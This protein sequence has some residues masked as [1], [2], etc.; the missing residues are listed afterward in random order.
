MTEKEEER[1]YREAKQRAEVDVRNLIS[2]FERER[3]IEVEKAKMRKAA[4]QEAALRELMAF[5]QSRRLLNF[6]HEHQSQQAPSQSHQH[7]QP[8]PK[9]VMKMAHHSVEVKKSDS[10]SMKREF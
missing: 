2:R 1:A 6:D 3:D 9:P 5:V 10:M 8:R 7:Q 4:Q